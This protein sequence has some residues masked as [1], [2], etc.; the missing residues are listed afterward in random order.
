MDKETQ[1]LLAMGYAMADLEKKYI[2]WWATG[3]VKWYVCHTRFSNTG[4]TPYDYTDNPA[5]AILMS[6]A[7]CRTFCSYL[8]KQGLE[9]FWQ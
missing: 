2:A 8:E 9:G 4:P 7:A 3:G 6:A 5:K 1:R